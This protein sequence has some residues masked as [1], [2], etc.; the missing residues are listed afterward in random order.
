MAKKVE[1]KMTIR[2]ALLALEKKHGE[3]TVMKLAK[4]AQVVK[5]PVLTTG[6]YSIDKVLGGGLP[7]G[8]V[9]EL[10]GNEAS[11]KTSFALQVIVEAQ[12]S[13]LKAAYID[14]EHAFSME[15]ARSLGVNVE[16]LYFS[17]PDSAEAAFDILSTLAQTGEF[18]II[19]LDS[20]AALVPATE[21]EGEIGSS[22]IGRLARFLSSALKQVLNTFAQH[23][24]TLILINQLRTKIG[25]AYGNPEYTTGGSALKYYAS[26]RIALRRGTKIEDK[27][28]A[29]I[30][31]MTM[32]RIEKNKIAMP[33]QTTQVPF[34]NGRGFDKIADIFN[35]GQKMGIITKE[36]ISYFIDKTKLG[37]GEQAS[38]TTL[39]ENVEIQ[40]MLR[41]K[42]ISNTD[43]SKVVE[44]DDTIESIPENDA[45]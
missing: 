25:I 12:K 18:A 4:G 28:G 17:Q 42:I 39:R 15:Y 5:V 8:R 34:L 27:E 20:V 44:T 16:E 43:T 24:T 9:I 13:G 45:A 38:L 3:G 1:G 33:F 36:K 14:I 31:Y 35:I 37:V 19:V 41:N 29:N 40:E 10:Y 26:Q 32:I 30:G 22:Q 11:G 2:E 6:I 7:R 21:L 23:G